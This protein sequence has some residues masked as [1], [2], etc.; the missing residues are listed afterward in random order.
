MIE[1]NDAASSMIGPSEH[2]RIAAIRLARFFIKRNSGE[3]CA[4]VTLFRDEQ[5]LRAPTISG[6]HDAS[7]ASVLLLRRTG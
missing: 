7:C 3:G 6:E 1:W 5:G 2:I 4:S